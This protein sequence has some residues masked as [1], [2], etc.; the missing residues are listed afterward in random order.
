[1]KHEKMLTCKTPQT[2]VAQTS[3]FLHVL[4]LL[5]VQ[6]QLKET[7]E[8]NGKPVTFGCSPA[9]AVFESRNFT[10]KRGLK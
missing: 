3:V 1:M 2:T 9:L 7:K 8:D 4:Q 6:T 10:L 5:H